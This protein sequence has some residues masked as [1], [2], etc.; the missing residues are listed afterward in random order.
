MNHGRIVLLVAI[1]W[2]A[3]ATI[4][5]ADT[6]TVINT[7]DTGTGSLRQAILSAN[8]NPGLDTIAF[9]IPGTGVHTITPLT[10]LPTISSPVTLDGYTQPGS[11]ANTLANGD[12]A[13]L[14]IEIS[15][16]TLG[17]NGDAFVLQAGASGSTIRGLVI[18]NGWSTAIH[19]LTDTIAVEGCFVGID[20]TGL[21][22]HGNGGG[23]N[24][25]SGAPTS[26]MRV[27]GTSPGQ[28]NVISGNSI[29]M[30]IS[31]GTNSVIEGNF[32]GTDATG[33]NALPN[34][35]GVDLRSSNNLIGGNNAAARNVIS[36]N[37][38]QGIVVSSSTGNRIQGNY[39]G[40]D[41]TGT[42][43]LGNSNGIF[44]TAAAQ[45]G[46]L[47]GTPG[48][49]PGNV[50]S[51]NHGSGGSGFG[52]VVAN[53]IN[54]NVIQ[55]NLIGTDA[56]G[57]QPLGNGLDGMTVHGASNVIGGS[58]PAARNV[59]SANGRFGIQMGTDNATVQDNLIQGN[60]IGTDITGINLLG[61]GSDGVSVGSAINN[62]IGGPAPMGGSP[63]ANLI[64]GNGGRGVA[65]AFGVTGL[66]IQGNSMFSNGGLGIDLNADGVTLNDPGDPD[67][68]PNNLQNY[69]LINSVVIASSSAAI[70]GT[71]NSTANT[72][73]RLE[74]FSN[75]R[76]EPSGFGEG[77]TFLGSANVMTDASG[78]ASYSVTF[79]VLANARAFTA[80]A[81]DPLGNTSE[82]SP[83]FLTR[84]LNIATRMRVLTGEKALIGGFI[85]TG[86][87]SKKVIVRGIGPS[88]SSFFSGVLAD[89]TLSLQG[90]GV[91][92]TN[93]N[94]KV[95]DSDGGSQQ[96]EIEATTIPPS[97]DLESATVQTLAP[98]AYTAI[99]SGKNDTIGI[100]LVEV[101]DLNQSAGA[102]LANISTRGFVDTG[103]NVMI[104]GLIIGPSTT[105]ATT[106]IVR[107]I[108]PTLSGAGITDPLQDPTLEL[109]DSS[110][111][112]IA[113][114]DNWKVRDSDGGSQQA[115]IEATTIPPTD[116]HESALLRTL[117]PGNYTAI[118][119][120][121]NNTTGVA[122]V[123]AYDLQ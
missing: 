106:V 26:G 29:G 96:A 53:N 91:F 44:M 56:T 41:V 104:G 3:V 122:L 117:A 89:T 100:G 113:T 24:A 82:F 25:E 32:I 22:P 33:T 37:S 73:F 75:D 18:D 116:D 108:G 6:F 11:S 4:A 21:I 30:L 57:T 99:L 51:G 114:N 83:A 40:T 95:R 43:A 71:L 14:R 61:N 121:K 87:D 27:G 15:G 97:N 67:T 120:G 85:I 47:T 103:D 119:R 2:S 84:L 123:E 63:P 109:H 92:V 42:H 17:S 36:G 66:A 7:D 79:P 112:T 12:N 88:L 35:G 59:I 102:R 45:I 49:P 110:G 9:T 105:G 72:A 31:S 115:E 38:S 70:N 64:A 50:I 76:A 74:F 86:S 98:G 8:A 65:V 94:W 5:F 68:G 16:A 81:T 58:D 10:Q 62:T 78:N 20:P 48:T 101:Y 90:S 55:G 93:D 118:V 13:I 1:L 69:P 60:F 46:G 80:T 54:N 28:R 107:A 111:A 23:V 77:G 39:I 34:S 19:I 52:I